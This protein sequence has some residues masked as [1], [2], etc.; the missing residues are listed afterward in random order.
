M[1]AGYDL[2]SKLPI[3]F[4]ERLYNR[5]FHQPKIIYDE[6]IF[7]PKE[8]KEINAYLEGAIGS[9]FLDGPYGPIPLHLIFIE[10]MTLI[11]FGIQLKDEDYAE[12]KEIREALKGVGKDEFQAEFYAKVREVLL[13]VGALITSLDRAIINGT[14]THELSENK[15]ALRYYIKMQKLAVVK[16]DFVVDGEK[17]PAFRVGWAYPFHGVDWVEIK[18]EQKGI[19]KKNAIPVFIQSHAIRRL[20]ERTNLMPGI[21]QLSLYNSLRMLEYTVERDGKLLISYFYY[22]KKIGYFIGTVVNERLLLQTFL[23]ITNNGTPEGRKLSKLTGLNPLDKKYLAIDKL[24]TFLSYNINDNQMVRD[25]FI[26]A[27]CGHLLEIE[28]KSLFLE[29]EG[30]E[31]SV[32]TIVQYL[33]TNP[34]F[35]I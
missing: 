12:A 14:M 28:N 31:I 2:Y 16:E 11:A 33:K 26:Q 24:S 34:L 29:E 17:R 23:F 10:G 27:G 6:K 32:E 20:E 5:R 19:T 4:R 13:I 15:Q 35:A 30:K 18:P 1:M 22:D 21:L 25:I 9:T 8:A 3:A 7:T